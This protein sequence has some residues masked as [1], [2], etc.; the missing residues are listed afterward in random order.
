MIIIAFVLGFIIGCNFRRRPS[1]R[2]AYTPNV[3]SD[4]LPSVEKNNHGI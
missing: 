2:G 3:K 1:L 4:I